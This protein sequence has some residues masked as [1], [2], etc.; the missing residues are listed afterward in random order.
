[1]YIGLERTLRPTGENSNSQQQSLSV[2]IPASTI[3]ASASSV[4]AGALPIQPPPIVAAT[5]SATPPS[6]TIHQGS[7][8]QAVQHQQPNFDL[9]HT[10]LQKRKA[11]ALNTN[12]ANTHEVKK[13][14]TT[15][16]GASSG[17]FLLALKYTSLMTA[18]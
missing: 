12:I 8:A 16:H 4:A 11:D 1:L 2:P 14:R 9:H 7:E 15:P 10:D 6:Q 17:M 13:I 5:P 18:V 3:N